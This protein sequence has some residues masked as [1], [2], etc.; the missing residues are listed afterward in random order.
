MFIVSQQ[1]KKYTPEYRREAANLVIESDRPIAHVAKEI[2]VSAG[3]LGRWVKLERER[4]G[5]SDGM[6]EADLRAENA[7]LRRELAEAKMDNEFLFKSDG[8]L[9]CEATR[10][11]KFELMRQEKANY[12]IKR[13]A[14]LL[15][16]S[17]SGYYKW[18]HAQQKRL[19]GKDD[20]VAFYD[21][22]DRKIHQIWKDSDEVYGAPRITAELTERYRISLNRKT[23]AKRMRMMGIEGISPRAFVP[24]T[25]IQ[26]KRKSTLPDLVKRMFDT[27]ELNRVWMSDITYLR[28]GEGWLY[29]CAVRDGHSRRVLGWAMDSVQDTSLVER[30]LRMA[31]TLRG[32][33][34]DGLV[35][36]ADRGT[37]FTSEKLWEVCRNLGIAQSVGRTGVC[38][39][40]A[41]A[42]SF[43]STL[44]T[45]FYDRQRW[46]TRDAARKA[47]AYWIE[48]VYN[49]R[50]SAL[51]MV[52]PVDFENHTGSINSRKE[53]A[54]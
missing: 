51:G 9:R 36:H 53:I 34:P 43:W 49:R 28:T 39:D 35:F 10:A 2:G 44:K 11:E 15:K 18:A 29:L 23:V 4:R 17:R 7:R 19:S 54:A 46:P 45:E 47:V 27:G 16:V 6:S 48:V 14:R 24:V 21:D 31:H 8:L 3:L 22:V 26:A 52:S 41:M 20:R 1:R 42:E 33:V 25:T 32:D 30:A 13:M 38:F 5:S 37:Q 40:N 12:S 50:H